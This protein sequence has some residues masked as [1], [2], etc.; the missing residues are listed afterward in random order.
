ML[1]KFAKAKKSEIENLYRMRAANCF[2]KPY[3]GKRENFKD[4]LRPSQSL[5]AIIAEYKRASPSKGLICDSISAYNHILHLSNLFA[6]QPLHLPRQLG[7]H[8]PLYA[9]CLSFN[10]YFLLTPLSIISHG[11]SSS[12]SNPFKNLL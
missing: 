2:P 5:P 8:S 1:E 10:K 9:L 4:A 3:S 7:V 12:S 11:N 6:P